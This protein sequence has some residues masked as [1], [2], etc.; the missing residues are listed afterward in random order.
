[1][2]ID[3]LITAKAQELKA[4]HKGRELLRYPEVLLLL[5][6]S[7]TSA[8]ALKKRGMFWGR[9]TANTAIRLP[10]SKGAAAGII[11]A[12]L[13]L[14]GCAL[15]GQPTHDQ[16]KAVTNEMIVAYESL[17]QEYNRL[18]EHF[19]DRRAQLEACVAPVMD[20]TK[21]ALV[22]L[23]DATAIWVRTKT[24]PHDWQGLFD[25]AASLL[26]EVKTTLANVGGR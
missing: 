11:I 8:D 16:A 21:R 19:P 26:G 18:H 9:F 25:R 20:S 3:S 24:K 6:I 2:S 15:K 14:P 23:G 10:W 12:V 7:R 13:L 17:Y 5:G 22:I 4:A 1:M